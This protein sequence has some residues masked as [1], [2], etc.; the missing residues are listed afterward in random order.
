M[1][2][3]LSGI[4]TGS[5]VGKQLYDQGYR[6][7]LKEILQRNLPEAEVVCPWEMNPDAVE[8]GPEKARQ[9][10]LAEVEAAASADLVVAYIPQASMGTAIE[11]WEASRKGVPILAI[12]PLGSNWVV[13]LLAH[14]VF[15]SIQDFALFAA[16][17]GLGAYVRQP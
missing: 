5:H 16:N 15:P 8:Y 17:G 10:F 1:K 7:E 3:F 9:T 11:M 14:Q 6:Q 13:M 2:I 4:I 12:S